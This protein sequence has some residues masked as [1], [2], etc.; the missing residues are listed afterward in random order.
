MEENRPPRF[1]VRI[2]TIL[3]VV[4]VLALVLT[5]ALQQ[6]QIARQR[7]EIDPL[8]KRLDSEAVL[9]DQLTHIIRVQRDLIERKRLLK[10]SSSPP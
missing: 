4:V 1:R 3:L 6:R 8:R 10:P 7:A 2:R 5:V 9:L